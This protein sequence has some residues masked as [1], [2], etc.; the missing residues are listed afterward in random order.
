MKV[1]FPPQV[2]NN[3]R[4]TLAI[5][6]LDGNI[7][8][9]V[10]TFPKARADVVNHILKMLGLKVAAERLKTIFPDFVLTPLSER[11]Q[12]LLEKKMHEEV[13]RDRYIP[14]PPKPSV[15][16]TVPRM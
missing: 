3:L 13:F 5:T 10:P 4:D 9:P 16:D 11:E 6:T 8:I 15:W 2:V 12:F 14:S 1:S 7:D